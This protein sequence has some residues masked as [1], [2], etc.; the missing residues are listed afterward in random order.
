M[1]EKYRQFYEGLA[2]KYDES[3]YVYASSSGQ[4]RRE[5]IR[6]WVKSFNSGLLLN[7]GCGDCLNISGL[8]LNMV[9][10]DIAF[11]ALTSA[12]KNVENGLF[13]QGDIERMDFFRS[14]SFDFAIMNEVIEHLQAPASSLKNLFRILKPGGKILI[15]CPN[16]TRKRPRMEK[17]RIIELYGVSY[18]EKNGYIH[19]A[20][21]PLELKE[22]VEN[23]G[24]R[25]IEYG[26][27]EKE[28]RYW[29]RA[30]YITCMP[31]ELVFGKAKKFH[32]IK[33]R[34]E[35]LLFRFLSLI[36]VTKLV[37][38]LANDGRRTYIIAEKPDGD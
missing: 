6:N 33:A 1:D 3:R 12:K 29:Q 24:F 11:G 37:V 32:Y 34:F 14:N 23:A 30:F 9:G 5:F 4:L 16:W 35:N 22:M 2:Q 26:T 20:Y 36:G 15:T 31:F 8:K 27:I 17:S 19:T 7:L 10:V 18:P 21:K 13:V 38:A 28:L 25:V